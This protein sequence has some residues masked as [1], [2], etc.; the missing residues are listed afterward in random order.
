MN[1]SRALLVL[2]MHRSGTSATS[3]ALAHFGFDLGDRLVA[4]ADD[5]PKG[6]FEHEPVVAIHEVFLET[7]GR[8]WCDPTALPEEAW[9]GEPAAVAR[10]AIVEAVTHDFH[11]SPR[12]S[13]KDPRLSRLLPLWAPVW[14]TLGVQASAIVV[15]RRPVEV[16]GSLARRDGFPALLSDLLWIRHTLE[17][18]RGAAGMPRACVEYS[19]MVADPAATLSAAL[20]RLGMAPA[21]TVDPAL[22]GFVDPAMNHHAAATRDREDP[23]GLLADELF[24]ACASRPDGPDNDAL[25]A[26]ERRFEQAALAVSSAVEAGAAA[27][28]SLVAESARWRDEGYATRSALNAQIRWSDAA[29]AELD[30]TRHDASEARLAG[31]ELGRVAEALRRDLALVESLFRDREAERDDLLVQRRELVAERDL[32]S[33][34]RDAVSMQRDELSRQRD[35]FSLER[36]ALRRDL[37]LL[38][39]SRSWRWTAPLRRLADLLMRISR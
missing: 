3:G 9:T 14:T 31:E 39:A 1:G 10:R 26:F 28:R 35:A 18:L 12:W 6:Y 25:D 7:L 16:A 33:R 23:I 38:L 19:R 32:V 29:A 5:N 11:A 15:V 30:R 22:T 13:L 20:A 2:G 4:A 8:R 36:D 27:F 21:G 34:Q 17:A 24:A 37:D